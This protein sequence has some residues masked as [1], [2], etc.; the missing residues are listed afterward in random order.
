MQK[1]TGSPATK[2]I[3]NLGFTLIELVATI[4]ILAILATIGTGFVVKTTEGYQKTQSRALLTNTARQALERMTRQLRIAFPYSMKDTNS[5]ACLKFMPIVGGGNYFN[6]VPDQNN[7]ALATAVITASPPII[8]FGSARYAT[9]GAINSD[10]VYG[11]FNT[12]IAAYT[13][14]SGGVLELSSAKQW[15]RNSINKRYYLLDNPQAF[16]L[17]GNELR[18]YEGANLSAADVDLSGNFSILARNVSSSAPFVLT[19]A[20]EN[21]LSGVII[22]LDFSNA[23][24]TINYTHQVL[25]RNVP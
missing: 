8:N 14:Y 3:K 11:S 1:L 20:S 12:S 25:I 9:I 22:S 13:S 4:V 10:E 21:R 23:G 15:Q 18:F 7:L 24:E 6:S 5:G 2:G 19:A 17:I 16:C